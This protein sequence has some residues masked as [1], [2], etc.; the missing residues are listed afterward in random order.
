[1]PCPRRSSATPKAQPAPVPSR[2]PKASPRCPAVKCFVGCPL[3]NHL[4]SKPS[5][6]ASRLINSTILT[7]LTSPRPSPK[8][9]CLPHEILFQISSQHVRKSPNPQ[10]GPAPP[11]RSA[12]SR[13][14][15]Q[16]ATINPSPQKGGDTCPHQPP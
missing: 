13:G 4:Q 10:R 6:R 11:R 3:L 8:F 7:P 15:G 9:F 12:P 1:M 14:I 5:R 2:T 16:I